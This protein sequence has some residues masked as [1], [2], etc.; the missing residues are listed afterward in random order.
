[1]RRRLK[2]RSHVRRKR[3][4]A[5]VSQKLCYDLTTIDYNINWYY[6]RAFVVFLKSLVDTSAIDCLKTL[7]S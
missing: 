4:S 6:I 5:T 7:V 3:V 1:V 2:A